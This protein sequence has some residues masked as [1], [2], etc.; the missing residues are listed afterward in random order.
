MVPLQRQVG[1]FGAKSTDAT[2]PH[3]SRQ[4]AKS[5]M[6]RSAQVCE[7]EGLGAGEGPGGGE[8]EGGIG[9][10]EGVGGVGEGVGR[11]GGEMLKRTV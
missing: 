6:P 2:I 5:K 10:G 11:I 1:G 8:G 4:L 7:A 3:A 9:V